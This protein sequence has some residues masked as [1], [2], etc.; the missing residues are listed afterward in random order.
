MGR[1][2]GVRERISSTNRSTWLA[3]GLIVVAGLLAA[4]FTLGDPD[5][6]ADTENG[7]E[8]QRVDENGE[9][10]NGEEVNGEEADEAIEED[11]ENGEEELP[12][13]LADTGAA[14]PLAATILFGGSGYYYFRSRNQVRDAQR[15]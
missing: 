5:E 3:L 12:S 6:L 4:T 14:L 7:N 1:F 9:E 10:A 15:K 2:D 11:E 8:E 13:E